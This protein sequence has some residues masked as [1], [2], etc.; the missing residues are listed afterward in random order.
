MRKKNYI[1]LWNIPDNIVTLLKIFCGEISPIELLNE[2]KI[3][4]IK[5]NSLRDKRRFFID[6]FENR[7]K[8]TVIDFFTKN[9]LL[10]ITDIIKGR[11]KFAADWMLVTRDDTERDETSWVLADINKAMSIFGEGEIKISPRGSIS[12]GRITLQRKGGDWG[13]IT[14]NMLQ[15]KIRPCDLFRY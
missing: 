15:F 6:E 8:K 14:G 11:G 10:I 13:R 7:H 4:Q 1:G 5:Y 2:K 12:I 3:T 9:K